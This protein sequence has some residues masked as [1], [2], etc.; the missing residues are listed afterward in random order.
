MLFTCNIAYAQVTINNELNKFVG[1]WRWTSGNDTVI[2]VLQKQVCNF[3]YSS[4][5][6]EILVGW[7]KY[8]KNGQNVEKSTQNIGFNIN[9]DDQNPATSRKITLTGKNHGANKIWFYNFCDLTLG[10]NCNLDF[11]LLTNSTTQ[12]SWKLRNPQGIFVGPSNTNGKFTLPKNLIL[13][14]I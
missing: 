7:H 12:A 8:I 10:K 2:I 9:S 4:K 13:T 1:T 14:K 11:Q 3:L 6:A 5:S